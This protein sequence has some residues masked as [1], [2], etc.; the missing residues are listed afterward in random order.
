MKKFLSFALAIVAMGAFSTNT[1]AQGRR[2]YQQPTLK[3]VPG[4]TETPIASGLDDLA[5]REQAVQGKAKQLTSQPWVNPFVLFALDRPNTAAA[6]AAAQGQYEYYAAQ[7]KRPYNDNVVDRERDLFQFRQGGASRL[8]ANLEGVAQAE[9]DRLDAGRVIA[10]RL[11]IQLPTVQTPFEQQA[12]QDLLVD[13]RWLREGEG[14]LLKFAD[15][16]PI[17]VKRVLEVARTWKERG[18]LKGDFEKELATY[19]ES[20]KDVVRLFDAKEKAFKAQDKNYTKANVQ[21]YAQA[22]D[23]YTKAHRALDLEKIKEIQRLLAY[24]VANGLEPERT[25]ARQAELKLSDRERAWALAT[26]IVVGGPIV[27]ESVLNSLLALQQ[28]NRAVLLRNPLL[29]TKSDRYTVKF[30]AY[31]DVLR[32]LYQASK[33]VEELKAAALDTN[34]K[35]GSV[36]WD[37]SRNFQPET[38]TQAVY[39]Q[40]FFKEGWSKL[41]AADELAEQLTRNRRAQIQRVE[42]GVRDDAF[43]LMTTPSQQYSFRW[44]VDDQTIFDRIDRL[45]VQFEGARSQIKTEV[46]KKA[47]NEALIAALAEHTVAREEEFVTK[48]FREGLAASVSFVDMPMKGVT[49]SMKGGV[50]TLRISKDAFN[51]RSDDSQA[52]KETPL[53]QDIEVSAKVDLDRVW[54]SH[55]GRMIDGGQKF[56]FDNLFNGPKLIDVSGKER[57]TIYLS[58]K[59]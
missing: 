50:L 33:R 40:I 8:I 52:A 35:V 26:H 24:A 14:Y 23:A 10:K 45:F 37:V 32:P 46:G 19:G 20:T 3:Y 16:E 29:A 9:Q 11:G 57:R 47:F 13:S 30:R 59:K 56:V 5:T 18:A 34:R 38:P 44:R 36:A 58:P 4:P 28:E 51:E 2:G 7:A 27:E 49:V 42:S 54:L 41:T 43:A 31:Q 55:Q 39:H 12:I 21:T 53:A 22:Y 25:K 15:T 48:L 6:R 17:R 1:S